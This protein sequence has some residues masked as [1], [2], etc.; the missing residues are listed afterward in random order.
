MAKKQ[1]N[2]GLTLVE[3]MIVVT[4]LVVLATIAIP[5]ISQGVTNAKI[6]ACEANIDLLNQAIENYCLTNGAFPTDL[7][8]ILGDE[9]LFPDGQLTCLIT[10]D[11]YP[12][13]LNA[14]SRVDV[15]NHNH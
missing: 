3:L 13:T 6:R 2:K 9:N 1:K 10:N 15:S 4:I 14:D 7:A 11:V 8:A 12:N 5:K